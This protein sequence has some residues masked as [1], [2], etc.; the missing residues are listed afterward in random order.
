MIER[1]TSSDSGAVAAIEEN[2]G[3]MVRA[4]RGPEIVRKAIGSEQHLFG[5]HHRTRRLDAPARAFAAQ[6]QRRR[7]AVDLRAGRDRGAR[8][9]AGVAERMQI[10]A[11][12]IKHGADVAVGA[13]HLAKLLAVQIGHRH[14]AADALLRGALDRGGAGLVVGRTQRAVLSRLARDLVAADQIMRE[15]RRAIGERDHAAA[16]LR[17][18]IGLDLIGIVLQA[19]IGVAAIV[20]G[21]APARLL[22]F[23]H[24]RLD[25]LLRQMQRGGKPRVAAAHD[26]DG[27]AL[28][29]IERRRRNR[30]DGGVGVE[31]GRQR[32]ARHYERPVKADAARAARN[33]ACAGAGVG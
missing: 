22:R 33:P 32:Q 20:A 10:A 26:R 28:V 11:A 25:A 19:G 6:R 15:I 14:A 12:S 4:E 23:Q 13:R 2:T 7:L 18:E 16:E 9:T 8:E 3:T 17:A 1:A 21:R 31:R 5:M 30:C 24:Q 29:R 27:N